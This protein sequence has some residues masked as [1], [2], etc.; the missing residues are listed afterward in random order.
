MKKLVK[1]QFEKH[2]R[3]NTPK[4]SYCDKNHNGFIGPV[5]ARCL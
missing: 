4:E 2:A 5:E 3:V 1:K